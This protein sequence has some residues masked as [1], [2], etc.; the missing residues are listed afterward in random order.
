MTYTLPR[1]QGDLAI[2][3][4][5]PGSKR[6]SQTA[7]PLCRKFANHDS[8]NSTSGVNPPEG[9]SLNCRIFLTIAIKIPSLC[10]S[11]HPEPSRR[12]LA[13]ASSSGLECLS[14]L[15]QQVFYKTMTY[16]L[17]ISQY[18]TATK[19]SVELLGCSNPRLGAT[20]EQISRNTLAQLPCPSTTE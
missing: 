14:S 2:A 3:L 7:H 4:K 17:P 11:E 12:A 15:V 13:E 16:P 5:S 8:P 18:V 20:I 1:W 19:G 9:A 10:R 6:V